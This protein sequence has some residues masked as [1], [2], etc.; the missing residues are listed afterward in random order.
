MTS[1]CNT[2]KK[3][4]ADVTL[5]TCAK[6][7]TTRYCSTDCQASDWPEHKITC[8][9]LAAEL[10]EDGPFA[11]PDPA[12]TMTLPPTWAGLEK[13]IT[14]PYTRLDKGTWLYDRP[15]FDVYRLLID[16][17]RLHAEDSSKFDRVIEYD[18]IYNG[19]RNNLNSFRRFMDT[20]KSPAPWWDASKQETCKRF[21]MGGDPEGWSCLRRMVTKDYISNRYEDIRF[22]KMLRMLGELVYLR[23]PGGVGNGKQMRKSFIEM[24]QGGGGVMS[25]VSLA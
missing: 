22:P 18:S 11:F 23:V 16:C 21:G 14:D 15:E 19:K 20:L 9:R 1:S 7:K 6:C 8:R 25:F 5:K 4:D 13:R 10:A 3:T 17:H 2:C 12:S 24:E